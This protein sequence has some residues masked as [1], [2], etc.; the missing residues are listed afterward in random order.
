MK[1]C[2]LEWRFRS[3]YIRIARKL[4]FKSLLRPC[5]FVDNLL[6]WNILYHNVI[7]F[8]CRCKRF[9]FLFFFF[10]YSFQTNQSCSEERMYK[11]LDQVLICERNPSFSFPSSRI[12][13]YPRGDA[14]VTWIKLQQESLS[15]VCLCTK[16]G[17]YQTDR[18]KW[19]SRLYLYYHQHSS[20][21]QH[22]ILISSS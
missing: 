1:L 2:S 18:G 10:F 5:T 8:H 14:I 20:Q 19:N 9:S 6:L 22:K 21:C 16:T 4:S 13:V 12:H 7:T 15:T 3:W 17:K 11:T